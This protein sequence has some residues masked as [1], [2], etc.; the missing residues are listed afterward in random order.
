SQVGIPGIPFTPGNGGLPSF[1][2]DGLTSFGSAT[3]QPTREFE[4]VFHFIETVSVIR[5][6]HTMK[7]GAEWKPQVNF[8]ILQPPYP[9][10]SFSFSG[11]FTKDPANRSDTGLGFADFLLGKLATSQVGSFINDT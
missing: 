6:R 10:G 3:Y 11:E 7:F 5:G 8:S 9:R 1:D 4:N 2:V